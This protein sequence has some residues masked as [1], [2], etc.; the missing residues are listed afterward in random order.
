MLGP[1]PISNTDNKLTTEITINFAINP[2]S[3][4]DSKKIWTLSA[5]HV[6]SQKLFEGV[7]MHSFFF[8]FHSFIHA[9]NFTKHC[10]GSRKL[11]STKN[12]W[13]QE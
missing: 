12:R 5:R 6:T 1:L 9:G 13:G 11:P 8:F 4:E 10:Q 7:R 3:G 2:F